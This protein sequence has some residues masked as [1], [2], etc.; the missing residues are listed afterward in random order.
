[1]RVALA[2]FLVMMPV[3]ARAQDAEEPETDLL[4][5]ASIGVTV[6]T[7][8]SIVHEGGHE[9][10]CLLAGQRP[11]GFSTAVAGCDVDT[12][13]GTVAGAAADLVSGAAMATALALAPP[14]DGASYYALWLGGTVSLLHGAGYLLVGPWAPAGDFSA[15]AGSG[16]ALEGVA[17]PLAWKIGLSTAGLAMTFGTVLLANHQG[18]PLFGADD[19]TRSERRR[20]LTWLPYLGGSALITTSAL[21]NRTGEKKY[22]VTAALANFGGTLFLAY[23][24]LFFNDDLFRPGE[25]TT[26]PALDIERSAPWLVAGA[27]SLVLALV[28]FGPGVGE[29]P[30]PHPLGR[31]ARH[32]EAPRFRLVPT[33]APDAP[34]LVMNLAA[35][36]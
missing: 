5:V 32:D 1:V 34:G 23:L 10:G 17:S 25:R 9:I 29:F 7:G 6:Y 12:R 24:P 3:A 35:R 31:L 16:G 20:L 28:V 14:D 21:F 30:R 19:E 18:E 22:A 13:L 2:A 15:A 8:K 4:T 11:Q 26:D 27:G 36:W 33:P